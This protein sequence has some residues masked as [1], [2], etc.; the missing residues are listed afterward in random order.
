MEALFLK[1]LNMSLTGCVLILA[2]LPIRPLLK[3]APRWS[4]CLLWGLVALRLVCPFTLKSNLSLIQNSEPITRETVS[5]EA[6]PAQTTVELETE[7]NENVRPM[8]EAWI[9]AIKNTEQ[10]PQTKVDILPLLG[11]VWLAG[12]SVMLLYSLFSY[13]QLKRRVSTATRLEGNIRQSEYVTSPFVLGVFC[14]TIYLPYG[15]KQPHLDHIL[16]HERSHIRRGDHL[17]KP[18]GFYIL[19]LHW[20]NPLVWLAYI[21]LCRDIEAACDERVI[22]EMTH[23]QRQSYSATL[24]CCS[25]HRRSITACPVA[26][27]ETGVKQRIKGVMSY[28]KP[29]L[30]IVI[31]ALL[32]GAVIGICFL[33]ERPEEPAVTEPTEQT[34]TNR[35]KMDALLD[36]LVDQKDPHIASDPK[37]CIMLNREAYQELLSYDELALSYFIP[38]LRKADIHSYREHMMVYVCAELTGVAF[39]A[40]RLSSSDWYLTPQMWV[41][42]YDRCVSP[43]NAQH[44]LQPGVYYTGMNI[45]NDRYFEVNEFGYSD[46]FRREYVEVSYYVTADSLVYAYPRSLNGEPR[47]DT[48]HSWYETVKREVQWKW[49]SPDPASPLYTDLAKNTQKA[50]M[51]SLEFVKE[52]EFEMLLTEDCLF[53]PLINTSCIVRCGDRIFLIG[54]V[55]S[56]TLLAR[57]DCV[58]ELLC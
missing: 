41:A 23:E 24:L 35:E 29:V 13:L 44:R 49:E 9:Q 6:P 32:A 12:T 25:V 45:H 17:I 22:K 16:S 8:P 18:L 58:V 51:K 26:F 46:L 15:L 11:Y 36:I 20:F 50:M 42:E 54:G 30:W 27:G 47:K 52:T 38:K 37:R 19:A 5:F 4:V 48:T 33:T 31:A 7:S 2:I 56:G 57:V 21:L 55:G 14:P 34:L 39:D 43:S 28:K 10:V 1:L 3:K 40:L 53:Q